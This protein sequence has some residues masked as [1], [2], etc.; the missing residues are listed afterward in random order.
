[1]LSAITVITLRI[2]NVALCFFVVSGLKR[3]FDI[4]SRGP[5]LRQNG[6]NNNSK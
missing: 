2:D 4:I 5:I 1:M 3:H 6:N